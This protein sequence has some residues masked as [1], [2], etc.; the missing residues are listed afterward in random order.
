M[1]S[2]CLLDGI[3]MNVLCYADDIALLEPSAKG[4]QK[5]LVTIQEGLTKLG[6]VVNRLNP[7]TL[8]SE[9]MVSKTM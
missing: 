4:L 6:L 3:K 1:P 8:C 9:T 5:I 2:G 7:H